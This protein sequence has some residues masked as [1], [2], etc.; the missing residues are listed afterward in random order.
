MKKS[1]AVRWGIFCNILWSKLALQ[2]QNI[3]LNNPMSTN[4]QPNPPEKI[5]ILIDQVGRL[6]EGLTETR[7]IVERVAETV[8]RVAQRVDHVSENLDRVSV[9][10]DR[11]SVTLDRVSATLD[12]V[13]ERMD[14]VSEKMDGFSE[15]MDRV[16]VTVERQA[17]V[18]EQQAQSITQLIALLGQKAS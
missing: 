1:P 12:R 9:N 17:V 14:R 15:R 10:L 13:S 11:A 6:T 8:E 5:D 3:K 4:G 18:A 2:F 7:L 16:S